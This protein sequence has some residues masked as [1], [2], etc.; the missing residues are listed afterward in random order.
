MH[1]LVDAER[2][3]NPNNGL[4]Q[5]CRF[6]GEELT[7]QRPNDALVTFLVPESRRGVFGPSVNYATP[8]W[9]QRIVPS[10]SYDV[11]HATHQ[12]SPF[13][14]SRGSRVVLTI[15]DLNFLERPDY[16]PAKK[17]RRLAAVQRRVDRASAIATISEYTA[18]VVRQHVRV[19]QIPVR[20]IYLG[21]PLPPEV[22]SDAAG[23]A[24]PALRGLTAGDRFLLF[25]GVLHPKKNVHTLLPTVAQ[26]PDTKLVLAG[27]D[28][29]SYAARLRA[30]VDSLG[31]HDRV[32]I[33]GAVDDETKRWLYQHASAL[34]FPSLSEG[35]GLPVLEAMA[36][37]K[38]AFLS[39]LTSLPEI[40][41]DAAFYFDSFEPSEMARTIREGLEKMTTD[42]GSADRLR[43][44]AS[45][46]TWSEAARDYWD[47]FA[48]VARK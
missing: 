25:V 35:F 30:E 3:R 45:Q 33:P 7:R 36:H 40:G 16:G 5:L 48:A 46:F 41:G 9:W 19:P 6:L 1:V 4:G 17:A 26:L 29:H 18:S 27:P 11:W 12:D 47:L 20:V 8:R 39:R 24:N 15:L 32:L 21:N 22:S 42:P 14:P 2:L 31:L 10:G 34:A 44:H 13:V 37:G 38:P 28:G 43:R 23:S